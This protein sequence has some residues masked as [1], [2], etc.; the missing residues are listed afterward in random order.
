MK[1]F[2]ALLLAF[3]AMAALSLGATGCNPKL[4]ETETE[5]VVETEED[6]TFNFYAKW[7]ENKKPSKEEIISQGEE[8]NE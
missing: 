8:T 2:V 5:Y 1:K 4:F 7:T 6:Q 3:V